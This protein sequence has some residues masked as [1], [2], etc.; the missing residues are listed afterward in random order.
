[1]TIAGI[2]LA[3]GASRRLGEPKQLLD[4]DGEPLVRVIAHRVRAATDATCVV[5]G[6][7][8]LAAA[9]A[10]LEVNIVPC[11]NWSEGMAASLRAG[12][13]WARSHEAVVVAACDQPD[14]DVGHVRALIETYR[15][16]GGVVASRYANTSGVP[17]LFPA[18]MFDALTALQG[19][20]GARA[21]LGN[22]QV[23]EWP[24][25][26]RDLDTPRAVAT[27]RDESS[28][29]HPGR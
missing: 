11:A 10:G 2:V 1:M 20:R 9:L 12:V 4:C 8:D 29:L 26:A 21:L 17:A 16:T 14:L 19:D 25:G 27:W 5:V 23:I 18:T 13:E 28:P 22:A 6:A 3:A 24:A 7:V 15:R